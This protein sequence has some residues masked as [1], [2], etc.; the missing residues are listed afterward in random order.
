MKLFNGGNNAALSCHVST[1]YII[2]SAP[3]PSPAPPSLPLQNILDTL[4]LNN[5]YFLTC[6]I[7]RIKKIKNFLLSKHKIA[8]KLKS[9]LEVVYMRFHFGST[10]ILLVFVLGPSHIAVSMM[11]PKMK[12]IVGVIS[13]QLF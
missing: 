4:L 5:L 12:L 9:Y 10:G 6:V 11:C 2:F 3:L 1:R 8:A 7:Q 13:W